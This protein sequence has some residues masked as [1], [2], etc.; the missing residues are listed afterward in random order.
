MKKIILIALLCLWNCIVYGQG[1]VPIANQWH[2]QADHYDSGIPFHGYDWVFDILA[3]DRKEY[4]CVGFTANSTS[5]PRVPVIFKLD[6]LGHPKWVKTIPSFTFDGITTESRGTLHSVI[7]TP[8]GYAACGF[9]HVNISSVS[10]RHVL[11][12]EF[13][14]DGDMLAG[15]PKFYMPEIDFTTGSTLNF[16]AAAAQ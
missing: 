15:Y 1:P 14:E 11:L 8:N 6:N 16:R 7:K 10:K 12:V 3:T 2:F 13:D 5:D 9:I 4:I